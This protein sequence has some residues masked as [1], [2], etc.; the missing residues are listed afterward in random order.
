MRSGGGSVMLLAAGFFASGWPERIR[1]HPYWL[2]V[3]FV[4][5]LFML[6]LPTLRDFLPRIQESLYPAESDWSP[7][8]V[9]VQLNQ[10]S[11][12]SPNFSNVGSPNINITVSPTI[13]PTFT[14]TPTISQ[15]ALPQI[16]IADIGQ[17]HNPSLEMQFELCE[18]RYAFEISRWTRANQ[19]D[20]DE[21]LSLVAWFTNPVPPKGTS[22]INSSGLFAHIKYS[23]PEHWSTQVPRAYWLDHSENMVIL[24]IGH[25]AGVILGC[26]E[27][28]RWV[29][30]V[31]PYTVAAE[32]EFLQPAFR[33]LGEKKQMPKMDM[34]IDLAL[35]SD[36]NTTIEQKRI[37]LAF[38]NGRP[39]AVVHP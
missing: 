29:A 20:H 31:N 39:Y 38:I 32:T 30:Y 5:G 22:G 14:N 8:I 25:E 4:V 13:S 17:C 19:F 37:S 23:V 36:N 2:L 28:E 16:A 7:D 34:T 12:V 6:L 18:L 3:F 27:Y 21:R 1:A 24:E 26:V 11:T 9:S 10:E 35:I 33:G 15:N